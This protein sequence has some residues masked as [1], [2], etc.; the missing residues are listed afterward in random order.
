MANQV[1]VVRDVTFNWPKLVDK[2]SPFGRLQWDVQ[3]VTNN[4]ATKAHL[5]SAGV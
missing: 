4:A 5:E 3:V 1:I 2:H